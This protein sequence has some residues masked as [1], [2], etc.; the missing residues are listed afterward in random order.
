MNTEARTWKIGRRTLVALLVGAL[1][2]LAAVPVLAE[3]PQRPAQEPGEGPVVKTLEHVEEALKKLEAELASMTAPVAERLEDRVEGL[4]ETLGA[5]L[6]RIDKGEIDPK[7]PATQKKVVELTLRLHRLIY[8]LD[9]MVENAPRS[10]APQPGLRILARVVERLEELA[11][12][13]DGFILAKVT[14]P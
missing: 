4:I 9:E 14:K 5:V 13:L 11:F 7:N 6:G 12:K 10:G 1:F 3:R 2:L 8:Q